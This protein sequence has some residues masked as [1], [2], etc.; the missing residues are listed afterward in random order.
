MPKLDVT[1]A[2][3]EEAI[4][5]IME[6]ID[7]ELRDVGALPYVDTLTELRNRIDEI[8]KNCITTY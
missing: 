5:A 7:D 1:I 3:N 4:Q 6:V 8:I 2:V